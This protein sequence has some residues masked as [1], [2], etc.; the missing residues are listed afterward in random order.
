MAVKELLTAQDLCVDIWACVCVCVC[1]HV[2]CLHL[3]V[4]VCVSCAGYLPGVVVTV[5]QLGLRLCGGTTRKCHVEWNI[6]LSCS[7]RSSS[8]IASGW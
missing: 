8:E 2:H 3:C 7:W 6:S 4:C 1:V 5:S